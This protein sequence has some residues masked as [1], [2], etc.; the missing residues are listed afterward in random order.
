MFEEPPTHLFEVG[1]FREDAVAFPPGV[2]VK[3]YT[4]IP[5]HGYPNPK[6]G[7]QP[8]RFPT[9]IQFVPYVAPPR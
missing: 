6:S 7:A 4:R 8:D 3:D 2:T 1:R 9:I 5:A